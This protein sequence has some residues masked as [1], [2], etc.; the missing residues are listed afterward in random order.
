MPNDFVDTFNNLIPSH[1]MKFIKWQDEED[2]SLDEDEAEQEQL[3]D[4]GEVED[5]VE[6]EHFYINKNHHSNS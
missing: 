4:E 6:P 1:I 2:E 5:V 3:R